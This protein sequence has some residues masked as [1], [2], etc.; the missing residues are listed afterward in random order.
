V[1]TQEYGC[2]DHTKQRTQFAEI[3]M[4]LDTGFQGIF[5]LFLL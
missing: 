2:G 1:T 3:I 4:T 5:R